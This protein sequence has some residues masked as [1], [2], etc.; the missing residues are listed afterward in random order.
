MKSKLFLLVFVICLT[1]TSKG[2]VFQ[3]DPYEALL[4]E[5]NRYTEK[6]IIPVMR[7][8]RK[9]LDSYLSDIDLKT[10]SYLQTEHYKISLELKQLFIKYNGQSSKIMLHWENL[11]ERQTEIWQQALEISHRYDKI[12]NLLLEKEVME[13]RT[14]WRMEM[15]MIVDKYNA[16]LD[17]NK[18]ISYKKHNFGEFMT[19]AGFLLWNYQETEDQEAEAEDGSSVYPNP[20]V[21]NNHIK[22]NISQEEEIIISLLDRQGKLL[23]ILLK[24]TLAPGQHLIEIPLNDLPDNLYFYKISKASG[25]EVKKFVKE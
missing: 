16:L 24:Q 8:Q 19:P 3:N 9:K 14:L 20:T 2:F 7:T 25:T 11:R 23:R 17:S 12:L 5:I 1:N 21:F 18:Q 22:L 13:D 15:N 6:H 4:E 10:I